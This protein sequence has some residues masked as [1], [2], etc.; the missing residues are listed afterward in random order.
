MEKS[1]ENSVFIELKNYKGFVFNPMRIYEILYDENSEKRTVTIENILSQEEFSVFAN[2]LKIY[3]NGFFKSEA[4][5]SKMLLLD[6]GNLVE[7]GELFLGVINNFKR[8]FSK[9]D[10][11]YSY[12][13]ATLLISVI[14]ATPGYFP[15]AII[16][17]LLYFCR[18]NHILNI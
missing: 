7:L 17:E 16:Y 5:K 18:S 11:Y 14:L 13:Y 12:V 8:T 4:F 15:D 9:D 10:A 1:F 6:D 3:G 2:S